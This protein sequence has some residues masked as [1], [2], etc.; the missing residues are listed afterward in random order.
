MTIKLYN[1]DCL[2]EMKDIQDKSIDCVI[3]DIPYFVTDYKFDSQWQNLNDY[4][5]WVNNVVEEI[6]RIAKDNFSIMLFTSRQYNR[7]I[8][9][10]LDKY[11]DEQRIII[12]NRKRFNSTRGKA[13]ASSY[14]PIAYYT[15]GN[16]TF[17]NIKIIPDTKR[18]EYTEGILKNG[19]N[20]SDVWSDIPA[21][22]HN[23]KEKVAHPTQKPVK[24]MERCIEICS[25]E[26]DLVLDFTMGSGSTGV[27][28]KNLN[29][30]F[31]G[32]EL[33]ENYFN[34][35]KERLHD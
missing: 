19:I 31:I 23:A 10:I 15:K 5:C 9:N 28:C 33:D 22:P 8:C 4:L 6:N 17:N 30:N 1:G 7:H 24:L 29:R 3:A 32:V 12:W 25:N 14:E 26:G 20:L 18:K 2:E 11:F 21:L 13:L 27:A 16:Y 35:A 34:I